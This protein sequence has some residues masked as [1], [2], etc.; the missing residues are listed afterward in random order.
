MTSVRSV[1]AGEIGQPL[2][3]ELVPDLPRDEDALR[4]VGDGA[5]VGMVPP[6]SR[7]DV[8]EKLNRQFTS[9]RVRQDLFDEVV[10]LMSGM[11][12]GGLQR[13]RDRAVELKEKVNG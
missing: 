11:D 7:F 1:E 8:R 2:V 6:G 4:T 5:L 13:L 12:A 10:D 3:L 9:E